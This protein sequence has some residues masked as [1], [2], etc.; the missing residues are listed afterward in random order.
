[1]EGSRRAAKA[2]REGKAEKP[3]KAAGRAFPSEEYAGRLDRVHER[4]AEKGFDAL[5][6]TSPENIYYLCGLDH[7][8]YFAFQMLVVPAEG[9]PVLIT[10]A[11]ERAIVRD[12]V[13]DV[14][15]IGY[16]DGIAPLPPAAEGGEDLVLDGSMK[17]GG[18]SGLRPWSMS[19]GVSVRRPEIPLDDMPAAA[20]STCEALQ[21]MG[22]ETS[23]LGVEKAGSFLPVKIY[24][25]L[26]R[27]LPDADWQDAS[28]VVDDCRIIQSPRELVYT[29]QA[30]AISEAMLFA[31]MAVAGPGVNEQDVMAAIYQA[32]FTRG[33]TYPGFVP[34]VRTTR[35]IQHEHGTWYNEQLRRGDMLF[36]E[37][38]GCVR[39]YHAPMGRLAFIGR[40][41]RQTERVQR[42]CREAIEKAAE[43]IAPGVKA[44]EVYAAWK[45]VLDRYG[46][47]HYHRHHCGYSVGIG[48][49]PSWSGSGVP[50]GLRGDSEMELQP[51]MVF[52][53]MSWML[54]T[55]KGDY[56]LSDTVI[57][58]ERG[59]ELLTGD[60]PRGIIVRG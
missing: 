51:G 25:E 18:R 2:R 21:E 3:A 40:V 57:V 43:A 1:M 39:R 16:S 19:L 58:T 7:Q 42:I 50:V 9:Q 10:R 53:L 59:A 14:R 24:E 8:G 34:L 20:R 49:P 33:G 29:R 37:M 23:R 26:R 12:R 30:A 11:M 27:G 47:S 41:P 6:I 17:G 44:K 54:R 5:L 4:M 48:Y 22:L 28:G 38:A 56:F 13:P 15:H 46:L 55:G 60:V 35:T 32:M 45:G 52:H 31:G 36:L